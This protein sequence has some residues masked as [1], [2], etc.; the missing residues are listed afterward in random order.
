MCANVQRD[1]TSIYQPKHVITSRKNCIN[2]V[3]RSLII[4]KCMF[5]ND[6]LSL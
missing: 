1:V 3:V 5:A 2:H 4:S 6:F